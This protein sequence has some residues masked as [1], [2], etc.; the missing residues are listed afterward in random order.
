ML[1]DWMAHSTTGAKRIRAGFPAD[2]KVIDKTGWAIT[3][4]PT[5]SQLCGRPGAF[6]TSW[7]SCPI[8]PPAGMTP[9]PAT[10]WS[11]TRQSVWPRVTTRP[12]TPRVNLVKF[13]RKLFQSL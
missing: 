9:N 1:A 12:K 3:G 4:E 10:L 6:P 5:T 7:R 11:L 8:V 2:W 13:G